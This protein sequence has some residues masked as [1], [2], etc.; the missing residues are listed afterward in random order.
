MEQSYEALQLMVKPCLLLLAGGLAAQHNMLPV[1]SDQS[2]LLLVASI[3]MLARRSLRSA[4]L[5]L[6]GFA[7]F[8]LAGEDII[9]KRL[10]PTYAGDSMLSKVRIV[11]FPRSTGG[12]VVMKGG[13]A[14]WCRHRA[15]Q[16]ESPDGVRGRIA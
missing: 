4:A 13:R 1:S 14:R 9:A 2:S 6:F 7:L 3:C 16:P 12:S 5:I 11:D 10:H 15:V 8:M